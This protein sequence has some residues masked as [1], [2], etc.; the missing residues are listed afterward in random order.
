M[1]TV[2]LDV[3]TRGYFTA[4]TMIIALPT[5]IKIFS[6]IATIFGGLPHFRT[7][8]LWS[9]GFVLLFTFGGFTGIILSNA[10]I[11]LALHDTYFVVGHFHYVLSLGVIYGLFAGV[12]Y[13]IGKILGYQLDENKGHIHFWVFTI[14][15]NIVFFP[16]HSLGLSGMYEII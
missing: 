15:I 13:Y 8:Y 9:I 14:A 6:W 10:S 4:A 12:Y 16:M 5:G 3:D 7:P 1:Y 11:D 2:G